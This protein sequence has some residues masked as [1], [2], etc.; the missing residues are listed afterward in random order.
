MA[1]A[2]IIE[3]GDTPPCGDNLVC[4]RTGSFHN[5]LIRRPSVKSCHSWAGLGWAGLGRAGDI[6]YIIFTSLSH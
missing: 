1:G 3:Y 4:D 2:N 5:V 6:I